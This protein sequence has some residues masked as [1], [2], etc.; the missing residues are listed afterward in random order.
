MK[1]GT[2]S[3]VEIHLNNAFLALLG[4]F[5]VAGVLLQGLIVFSVVLLHE[6]AHV[7]AA[8]LFGMTASDV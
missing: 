3:G 7:A 4:L 5:F 6:L 1:V 2:V 8:R